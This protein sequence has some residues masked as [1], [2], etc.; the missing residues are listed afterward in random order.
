[1]I[2][3]LRSL[4]TQIEAWLACREKPSKRWCYVPGA[5]HSDC[6]QEEQTGPYPQHP[7]SPPGGRPVWMSDDA[8]GRY[9]RAHG[10]PRGYLTEPELSPWFPGTQEPW[11]PGV[12]EGDYESR[13]VLARW[14]G[15]FWVY[16]PDEGVPCYFQN[17]PW[18][19]LAADPRARKG[20]A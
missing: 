16:E 9:L 8:A 1:M 14:N 10:D 12:Y 11:E 7:L 6:W 13:V 2:R 15:L 5:E 20:D 17:L 19:G 3:W 18:R 4:F